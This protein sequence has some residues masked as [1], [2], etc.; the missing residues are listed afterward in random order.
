MTYQAGWSMNDRLI[1]KGRNEWMNEHLSGR[2]NNKMNNE[3][4]NEC[5]VKEQFSERENNKWV[6]E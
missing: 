6:H 3:W 4:V 1:D 5:L 2:V